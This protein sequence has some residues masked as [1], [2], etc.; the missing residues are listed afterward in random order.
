MSILQSTCP[1]RKW[2]DHL[3]RANG[4]AACLPPWLWIDEN[5]TPEGYIWWAEIADGI[6]ALVQFCATQQPAAD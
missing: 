4:L 5:G 1:E 3:D 2:R 6:N